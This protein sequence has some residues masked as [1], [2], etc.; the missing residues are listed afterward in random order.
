MH[1]AKSLLIFQQNETL[2]APMRPRHD[3]YIHREF[4]LPLADRGHAVVLDA[5]GAALGDLAAGGP[6]D[7]LS[8]D[9]PRAVQDVG[10]VAVHDNG[11]GARG[12]HCHV[13]C[14]SSM[15]KLLSPCMRLNAPIPF[16]AIYV[17]P[18]TAN[19]V[20]VFLCF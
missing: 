9:I 11:T 3:L 19:F 16:I 20:C 1:Y 8:A 10:V 4:L 13:K 7:H 12:D 5:K 17:G 2:P 15:F 6:R 18:H 14:M